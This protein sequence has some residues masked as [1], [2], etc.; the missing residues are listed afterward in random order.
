M[1]IKNKLIKHTL[2]NLC[3]LSL[4]LVAAVVSIPLLIDSLGL[5]RFGLLTFIWTVTSYFGL[6]D[7]GL[8]RTL[9]QQLAMLLAK[10]EN[11]RIGPLVA[12]ATVL[13]AVFGVFAGVLMAALAPWGLGHIEGVPDQQ[14][15]INAVY[16]MALAMPI[17]I[18]T[19]GFRGILEAK[20]A[21]GILNLIRLPMG[22]FT[23]LG[24]LAVVLY[25][26]PRL[27]WIAL[28]LVTGRVLACVVH[29][30]YAWRVLPSD[31]GSMTMH[32]NLLKPLCVSG[33]WMT[34]SN[35]ISPFM[36]YVDRFIIGA[37]IS[38]SAVA[39]YVTPQELVTKLWIIP[40][41]LTGVLFPTFSAQ[42]VERDEQ[43]WIL[44]KKAAHWLF[45]ALLPVTAG[46][47]L[48]ANEL[49][50]LWISP[51]FATHSAVLLQIF[52]A[53]ILINCLAF[54]PFA[55]IQGAG[56]PKL[57]ALIHAAELPFFLGML[58][59]LA[60]TYGILGAAIAWVLRITVDAVLM[61][62]V[63]TTLLGHSPKVLLNTKTLGML[64][65]AICAFSGALFPSPLIRTFWFV[66]VLCA[67]ALTFLLPLNFSRAPRD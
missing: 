39:Y 56:K 34:M 31:H 13:M 50:S 60:S 4:P 30:W 6:F 54:T 14:E 65:L 44:F 20:H 64:I 3:G 42:M 48:F 57:T 22:L 61:F 40:G 27:D 5:H 58:W 7:M 67:A 46:I 38:S 29:A 49:L 11:E 21:F 41:A 24:P 52:S 15:A 35:I 43:T 55:L 47:M 12:T 9:T 18:L 1:Q 37:I 2:Y 32:V 45:A 23:F 25:G 63:S 53:G 17:I 8:S 26:E 51:E 36:G 19:A 59:W 66:A 62:S 33:G 28:V 10:K 16:L